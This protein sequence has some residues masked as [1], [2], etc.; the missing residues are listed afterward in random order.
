MKSTIAR[1]AALTLLAVALAAPAGAWAQDRAGGRRAERQ[2]RQDAIYAR[3]AQKL[4]LTPEQQKLL[5]EMKAA[6]QQN[7]RQ[8]VELRSA[9]RQRFAREAQ[10]DRPDFAKAAADVKAAYQQQRASFDAMTDAKARFYASLSPDQ[11]RMLATAG[12]RGGR[13]RDEDDMPRRQAL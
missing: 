11:R 2:E 7:R 12:R 9:M 4:Q 8:Q 6:T 5:D 1:W 10:Q 13:G 3:L